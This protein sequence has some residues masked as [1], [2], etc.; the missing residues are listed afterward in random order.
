MGRKSSIKAKPPE[1]KATIDELIEGGRHTLDEIL[2]IV[3]ERHAEA[4]G[5]DAA[6]SR[7]ALGRYRASVEQQMAAVRESR[8][9]ADVW[10]QK[11]G[12]EPESDVGKV[13]LEIIRTLAYR[14]GA[15]LM[16]GEGEVDARQLS[17]LARVMQ[18]VEDAGRLS[19]AREKAVRE[20]AM[21]QVE[22]RVDALEQ[23]PVKP[24]ANTL[25]MVRAAIR[26]EDG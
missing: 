8:D 18:Q 1:V 20:A 13:V 26:G 15:D 17:Q 16:T 2:A 22:S 14:A 3:R 24:D 4:Y 23:G 21:E 9:I 7:A 5:A 6:P 12:N 10:A 11:L 19:L 25:Q